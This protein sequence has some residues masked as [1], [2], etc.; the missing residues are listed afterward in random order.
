M[1]ARN[2]THYTCWITKDSDVNRALSGKPL[3]NAFANK[4]MP[5]GHT[6]AFVTMGADES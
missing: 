2:E 3:N 1:N 6:A 4:T 5:P